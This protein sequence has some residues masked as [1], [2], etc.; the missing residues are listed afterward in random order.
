MSKT[1]LGEQDLD[2]YVYRDPNGIEYN[3]RDWLEGGMEYASALVDGYRL[4]R[5]ERREEHR[6]TGQGLSITTPF[7][8]L[9]EAQGQHHLEML[10]DEW[11]DFVRA[12]VKPQLDGDRNV[13]ATF[14]FR[15]YKG[16]HPGIAK[17]REAVADFMPCI[18][19]YLDGW[20]IVTER[21]KINDRLHL[22]MVG[23]WTPDATNGFFGTVIKNLGSKWSHGWT[24]VE[25]VKNL[26]AAC[27]YACKYII[28]ELVSGSSENDFWM[29]KGKREVQLAWL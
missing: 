1:V 9:P 5:K 15:D 19:D 4:E 25:E 17:V 20:V 10:K 23:R 26:E 29:S 21:G 27:K 8:G 2:R 13:F 11:L 24:R 7:A 6:S 14:T 18:D 3:L 22:H 12:M 28:K 16:E